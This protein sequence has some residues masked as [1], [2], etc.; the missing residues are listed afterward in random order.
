LR[1]DVLVVEAL[2]LL[3]GQLHHLAGPVGKAFIHSSRLRRPAPAWRAGRLSGAGT[4][5]RN[6]GR[7]TASIAFSPP[8]PA[9]AGSSEARCTP[10][11]SSSPVNQERHSEQVVWCRCEEAANPF[12]IEIVV[13]GE[14]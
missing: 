9:P 12:P 11:K 8:G 4:C 5:C 1:A 10:R 3:V 6:D 13:T 2:G 7:S 14:G